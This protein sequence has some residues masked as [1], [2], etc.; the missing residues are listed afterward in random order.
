[1]EEDGAMG[2]GPVTRSTG[3]VRQIQGCVAKDVDE[4]GDEVCDAENKGLHVQSAHTY[5]FGMY[6]ERNMFDNARQTWQYVSA[7][8]VIHSSACYDHE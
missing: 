8:V 6:R 2:G 4:S 5:L 7:S 1:M 3:R